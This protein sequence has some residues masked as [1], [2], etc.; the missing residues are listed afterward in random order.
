LAV[1]AMGSAIA[2]CGC[3][4]SRP[5]PQ[6]SSLVKAPELCV[7]RTVQIYF[8]PGSTDLTPEGRAVID[9]AAGLV[10][11][12]NVLGV[13]VLGLA[14][15]PGGPAI[16]MELSQR[17]AS[18]VSAALAANGLPPAEFRVGAAGSAAAVAEGVRSPLRRRVDVTF[19]LAPK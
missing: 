16:N 11:R 2:L 1:I 5:Q 13:D 3:A 19:R 7:E 6:R 18:A 4:S 10:Q 8:E 12:C 14:D 17:R 15:A 9:T